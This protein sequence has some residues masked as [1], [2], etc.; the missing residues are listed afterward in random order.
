MF[1]RAREP[2]YANPSDSIYIITGHTETVT[3]SDPAAMHAVAQRLEQSGPITVRE[4]FP[5]GSGR[6]IVPPAGCDPITKPAGPPIDQPEPEPDEEDDEEET[7]VL[8]S[9]YWYSTHTE[10]G[11]SEGYEARVWYWLVKDHGFSETSAAKRIRE[12]AAAIEQRQARLVP[13]W[14]VARQLASLQFFGQRIHVRRRKR[15]WDC[16]MPQALLV[17]GVDVIAETKRLIAI[18][19]E[20]QGAPLPSIYVRRNVTLR[21]RHGS[22]V[23][24][25]NHIRLTDAPQL[26]RFDVVETL[27][28]ELGHLNAY[29]LYKETGHGKPWKSSYQHIVEHGYGVHIRVERATHGEL[30]K[31]LRGGRGR[32]PARECSGCT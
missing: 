30:S 15:T 10:A 9:A 18:V 19:P 31:I 4:V 14:D 25:K 20:L 2:F 21:R 32:G 12:N 6:W 11:G 1:G 3:V 8:S 29:R 13:E 24:S 23:Y 17:A 7:A 22:A 16:P 28:H 26:D 27:S 5:D